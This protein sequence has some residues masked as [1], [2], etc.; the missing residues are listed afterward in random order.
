MDWSATKEGRFLSGDCNSLIYMYDAHEGHW[1]ADNM[2]FAGHTASVEDL[3]W[4]PSEVEVFASCSVDKTI[5][6]WD[7]RMKARPGL[8][9]DAHNADVNVISW[10]KYE[11]AL[12]L[13][14]P[15]SGADVCRVDHSYSWTRQEGELPHALWRRRRHL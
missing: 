13:F 12:L 8:S 11:L 15:P 7:T 5:K 3:Q 2:P 10:N 14:W 6:I 4:S 9:V 1:A